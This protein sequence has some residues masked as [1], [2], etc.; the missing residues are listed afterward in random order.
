MFIST[1]LF[2]GEVI[3]TAVSRVIDGDTIEILK[4]DEFVKV[5]PFTV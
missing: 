4:D 1:N 3:F 5:P 2:A